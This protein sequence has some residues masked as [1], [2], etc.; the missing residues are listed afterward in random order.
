MFDCLSEMPADSFESKRQKHS[1]ENGSCCKP[2]NI[3]LF[4][5]VGVVMFYV[6]I[7]IHM[8]MGPPRAAVQDNTDVLL[9]KYNSVSGDHPVSGAAATG[10]GLRRPPLDISDE[11]S[12]RAPER[13]ASSTV[14]ADGID[15]AVTAVVRC[16][17]SQGNLTID[18]RGHWAPLGAEQFLKLVEAEMFTDLPFFRVCPRYISKVFCNLCSFYLKFCFRSAQF[19][20]KFGGENYHLGRLQDDK[21]LW[22]VRDMNFGYV[23]FAVSLCS[24]LY[25]SSILNRPCFVG[26]R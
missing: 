19:G 6:V 8:Y 26:L 15:D 9:S 16:A 1:G 10:S 2:G 7:G 3:V 25:C 11:A 5:L 20:P 18:V 24:S 17:T 22:G 4:V 23:F 21:S 12:T 14:A 13:S